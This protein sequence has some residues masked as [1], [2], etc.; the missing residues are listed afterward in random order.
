MSNFNYKTGL[1]NV[2]SY[3]VSGRPWIT[4]SAGLAVDVEDKIVFPSVAKSVMVI[5]RD[6]DQTIDDAI[7]VHFNSTS[8]TDVIAGRHFVT[9][10]SYNTAITFNVKCTE[11]YISNPAPG[12]ADAGYT[13]VA[14]L[15]G[16]GA[17]EMPALT[18]SGLTDY[19]V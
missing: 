18:G 13:V 11:I 6:P 2:G 10:D 12:T 17:G 1:Y 8:S 15:T 3:Q 9:L 14:E 4:G 7:R 5:N 19:D 16:I